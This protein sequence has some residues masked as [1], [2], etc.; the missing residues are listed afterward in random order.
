MPGEIAAAAAKSLQSC[1]TLCNPIDGSLQVPD[2]T[3]FSWKENAVVQ[4]GVRVTSIHD[5]WK[6]HSLE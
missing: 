5:H 2:S 1:P 6:N 3:E 4:I